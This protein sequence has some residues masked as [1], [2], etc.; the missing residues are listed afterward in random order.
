MLSAQYLIAETDR[1]LATMPEE[2]LRS[3][4]DFVTFLCKRT[5]EEL[6]ITESEDE[7][8]TD[9]AA[10]MQCN[11]AFDFLHDEPDLYTEADLVEK[12]K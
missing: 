1:L 12:Y 2:K 9:I 11:P 5:N 8:R 3:V 10:L 7:V 4:Y 6:P